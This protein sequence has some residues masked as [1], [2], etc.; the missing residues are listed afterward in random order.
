MRP[1]SKDR[2]I[3]PNISL[4]YYGRVSSA[5]LIAVEQGFVD[6]ATNRV[7]AGFGSL[8]GMFDYSKIAIRNQ[9][10]VMSI[11]SD[12]VSGSSNRIPGFFPMLGGA[13]FG[14]ISLVKIIKYF[15]WNKVVMYYQNADSEVVQA[16]EVSSLAQK[17]G[18][19]FEMQK[20]EAAGMANSDLEALANAKS[21]IF[22]FIGGTAPCDW[23]CT[24]DSNRFPNRICKPMARPAWHIRLS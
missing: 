18:I 8:N 19:S 20:R 6:F 16:E 11:S 17:E 15:G 10:I 1:P 2:T 7:F 13:S 9:Q 12:V 21:N 24:S 5:A 3:L 22:V 23:V 14:P 4:S